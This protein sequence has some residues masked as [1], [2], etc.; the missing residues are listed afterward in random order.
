M[1]LNGAYLIPLAAWFAVQGDWEFLGYIGFVVALVAIL[2][3][4]IHK[5]HFPV[6]LLALLSVWAALHMAG[7]ALVIGDHVLYWHHLVHIVGSGDAYVLRFDQLVHFYGF[8][9]ATFVAYWLLL[10][11]LR[12][13]FR[14]GAVAFV[15]ALAGMGFGALNEIVEFITVLAVPENGVGG[16]YNTAIDIVANA[17]GATVA[18]VVIAYGKVGYRDAR[19]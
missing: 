8:F 10:P 6:W 5:T 12:P 13:G 18:A 2:M 4:T 3:A 16:Y 7:G 1:A 17:L 9:T 19:Q 11:Q 15:A 14:L